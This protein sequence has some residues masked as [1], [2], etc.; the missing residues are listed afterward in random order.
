MQDVENRHVLHLE[1][2]HAEKLPLDA[3]DDREDGHDTIPEFP[4]ITTSLMVGFGVD[5][6]TGSATDVMPERWNMKYDGGDNNNGITVFDISDTVRHT[7]A[8]ALFAG[9]F[10][11]N[12][13]KKTANV[14]GVF[15]EIT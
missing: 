10:M 6:E 14:K 12:R 1:V 2:A 13:T 11:M 3:W 8:I 9:I 7:S 15:K 4:F 5:F